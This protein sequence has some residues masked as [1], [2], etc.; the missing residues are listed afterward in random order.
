MGES[1]FVFSQ[2]TGEN[3]PENSLAAMSMLFFVA[4]LLARQVWIMMD[5]YNAISRCYGIIVLLITAATL[6]FFRSISEVNPSEE[7]HEMSAR[8]SKWIRWDILFK[9]IGLALF[10]N[11]FSTGSS[12]AVLITLQV[13]IVSHL[14]QFLY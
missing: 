13:E 6:V 10:S 12:L 9:V 5:F 7:F 8:C 2:R 11:Y 3:Y 1:T 4:I 14:N